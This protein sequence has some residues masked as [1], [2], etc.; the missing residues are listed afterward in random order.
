MIHS[1]LRLLQVY[2]KTLGRRIYLLAALM[3]FAAISESIGIALFLP[4][5]GKL[6]GRE[7]EIEASSSAIAKIFEKLPLP[8]SITPLLI[9]ISLIFVLKGILKFSIQALSGHFESNLGYLLRTDALNG[10]S[11]MNNTAFNKRNTGHYVS[12]FE[13]QI[14]RFV[15]TFIVSTK[16]MTQLTTLTAFIICAALMDWKFAALAVTFGGGVMALMN[17]LNHFIR[18]FS[19]KFAR[20][21]MAMSKHLIHLLQ[22]LKY[23]MATNQTGVICRKVMD[24]CKE[25]KKSSFRI[26][27]TKGFTE[28][29]REPISIF[30]ILTLIGVQ[31]LVFQQPFEQTLVSL[32]LLDRVTKTLL[33]LQSSA[34]TLSEL[35]GSVEAVNKEINYANLNSE[36]MGAEKMGPFSIG[37]EFQNVTFA[38][39]GTEG[40]VLNDVS[41][42]I[43]KNKTVALVGQSGAGKSTAAIMLPL[44]IRPKKGKVL[45]DGLDSASLDLRDWR[46]QIGYVSQDLVVFDDTIAANICFDKEAFDNDPKIRTR[47]IHAAKQAFADQFIDDLPE[48]FDTV[49]GDRGLRLSGGQKQ[50]LFIAR[51]LY[52]NPTILILDEATSALDGGSE[53]AIQTSIE[54]LHGK[55]TVIVIAHRLAT[56]KNVDR[57]YVMEKGKVIENG[58]YQQL[59]AKKHS[60]FRQMIKLQKL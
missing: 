60:T 4:L 5:L 32:L 38:Y 59:I 18:K 8:S 36:L 11:N 39:D 43:P 42:A 19:R 7:P 31:V 2:R 9:L 25:L 29:I 10:W 3:P 20:G 48:T 28:S 56:I 51:E 15:H 35:S 47:V 17:N 50:R 44:L 24:S 58:S 41:I 26:Y 57:I 40:N 54:A 49:V 12:V 14:T 27:L 37:V 23:L 13:A 53:R 1:F 6:T 22:S 34:Q 52:R 21:Q 30:L 55:I 16:I 46:S 33:A 45:I